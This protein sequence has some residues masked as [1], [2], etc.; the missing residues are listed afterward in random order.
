MLYQLSIIN[1]IYIYLPFTLLALKY[2]V[3]GNYILNAQFHHLT[4]KTS[5]FFINNIIYNLVS[6]PRILEVQNHFFL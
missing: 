6:G 1:N 2:Q 3:C 5:F 4:M